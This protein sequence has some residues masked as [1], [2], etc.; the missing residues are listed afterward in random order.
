MRVLIQFLLKRCEVQRGPSFDE[1]FEH[2]QTWHCP[3]VKSTWL[4][5]IC[6]GLWVS[7]KER[8]IGQP[9]IFQ[10]ALELSYVIRR[11]ANGEGARRSDGQRRQWR[12]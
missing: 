9:G 2:L 11:K 1:L 4:R 3:R 10:F 7:R 6:V 12:V 8:S 5:A